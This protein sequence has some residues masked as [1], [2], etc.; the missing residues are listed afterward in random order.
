VAIPARLISLRRYTHLSEIGPGGQAFI[1]NVNVDRHFSRD[2]IEA[3]TL[4]D[5]SSIGIGD[6]HQ[7]LAAIWE[8]ARGAF[9]GE[10]EDDRCSTN[11]FFVL[12]DYANS[13]NLAGPLTHGT[14]GAVTLHV[15]N[16]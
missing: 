6:D 16:F 3:E 5:G 15:N 12:I 1:G 13:W 8:L 7:R 2:L 11:R 9:G 14:R 10:G 4:C